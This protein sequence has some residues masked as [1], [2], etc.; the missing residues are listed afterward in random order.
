MVISMDS[1]I[2]PELQVEGCARDI[3]R[4]IQESRKEAGYNVDDRIEISL[5]NADNVISVFKEYIQTETL[6]TIV[7]DIQNPD[8]DKVLKIENEKVEL[9]LKK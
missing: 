3:V 8:I 2:T 4:Q 6:S 1:N 9:K 5:T 7:E